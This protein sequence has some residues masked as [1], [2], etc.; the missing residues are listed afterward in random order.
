MAGAL[1]ECVRYPLGTQSLP[2]SG[3]PRDV[4]TFASVFSPVLFI[5]RLV[6]LFT[7]SKAFAAAAGESHETDRVEHGGEEYDENGAVWQVRIIGSEF[8]G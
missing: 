3:F 2:A 7:V 8:C 6:V 4:S 5:V 1:A